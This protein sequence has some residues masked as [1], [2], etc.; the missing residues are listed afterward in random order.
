MLRYENRAWILRKTNGDI[1]GVL[2]RL[3]KGFAVLIKY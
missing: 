3:V 2:A 1:V